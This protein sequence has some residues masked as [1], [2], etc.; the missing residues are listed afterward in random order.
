MR[1]QAG[2]SSLEIM[3]AGLILNGSV[4]LALQWQTTAGQV[5]QRALEEYLAGIQAQEVVSLLAMS[6]DL[7]ETDSERL[8]NHWMINCRQYLS[9]PAASVNQSG[10][11]LTFSWFSHASGR[12]HSLTIPMP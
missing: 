11:R 5:M 10:Q 7:S 4:L 8:I 3:V 12:R 9:E 2:F 1:K 6:D